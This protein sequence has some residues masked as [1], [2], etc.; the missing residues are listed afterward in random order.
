MDRRPEY[1]PA[2]VWR[3][4]RELADKYPE[5]Q[6]ERARLAGRLFGTDR[7][8]RERANLD[9]RKEPAIALTWRALARQIETAPVDPLREEQATRW[10]D[11]QP[12]R[13]ALAEQDW[14]HL[15]DLLLQ[16]PHTY[17]PEAREALRRADGLLSEIGE[18]AERLADL[19]REYSTIR[20]RYQF[21]APE[22]FTMLSEWLKATTG[23][24]EPGRYEPAPADMIESLALA[25][26]SHTIDADAIDEAFIRDRKVSNITGWVR[27]FDAL[28]ARW[29]QDCCAARFEVSNTDLARIASAVLEMDI[30]RE[31]VKQ[32]RARAKPQDEAELFDPAE[33][34]E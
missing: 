15:L 5:D 27:H 8:S 25:A 19:L 10:R 21:T 34:R 12:L 6:P 23:E 30:S 1:L 16:L 17:T 32:A 18:A 13:Q 28:W 3:F 24:D 4:Y 7:Q 20:E 26:W 31:T 2:A 33:P 14:R 9:G 22:L 29:Q 11:D